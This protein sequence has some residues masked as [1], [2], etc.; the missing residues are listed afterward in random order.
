MSNYAVDDSPATLRMHLTLNYY[1][2][3]EN[4]Y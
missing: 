3:N 4:I 1:E 2:N